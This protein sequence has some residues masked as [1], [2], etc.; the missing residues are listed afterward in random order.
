MDEKILRKKCL[1]NDM[2]TTVNRY[3]GCVSVLV[4]YEGI[5][6]AAAGMDFWEDGK[7]WWLARVN[8]KHPHRKKGIGRQMIN[9]LKENADGFPIFV[10]PGGYDLTQEEQFIF[11]ERCGFVK[12]DEHSLEL[13]E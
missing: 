12:K 3:E 13:K 1:I 11:Y 10:C 2:E 6:V 9:L 7:Y 8:V 4:I 5:A